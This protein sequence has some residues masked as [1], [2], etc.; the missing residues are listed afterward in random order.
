[1]NTPRMTS[2]MGVARALLATIDVEEAVE[3]MVSEFG[4]DMSFQALSLLSGPEAGLA[5]AAC[6]ERLLIEPLNLDLRGLAWRT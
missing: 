2:V 1:M 3:V 5:F 4:W 6:W